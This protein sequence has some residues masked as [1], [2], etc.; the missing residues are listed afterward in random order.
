MSEKNKLRVER[1]D[2]YEIE[3]NDKGE[4]IV[5]Y[6]GDVTL[7]LR[8]NKAYEEID[9]IQKW[10]KAQIVVINKK[11]DYTEKGSAMSHN[12]K[13]IMKVYEKGFADM[14]KAMDVFLGDGGCQKVFGDS[15]YLEMYDD[16]WE[17][18]TRKQEDGL[19]HLDKMQL[20]TKAITQRIENKYQEIK[21]QRKAQAI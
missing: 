15:D 11:K 19:S 17:E 2:V 13:E 12:N 14:R 4:T 7:P 5:F 8:M 6:M 9:K 3:V 21:K 10:M 1:K 20:S 16:L 18:L